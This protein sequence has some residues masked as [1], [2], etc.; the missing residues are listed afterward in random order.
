MEKWQPSPEMF[1]ASIKLQGSPLPIHG[2]L[3]L[4]ALGI[5]AGSIRLTSNTPDFFPLLILNC[6]RSFLGTSMILLPTMSPADWLGVYCEKW[7]MF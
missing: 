1:K 5:P 2:F 4:S 7:D 6:S 3:I